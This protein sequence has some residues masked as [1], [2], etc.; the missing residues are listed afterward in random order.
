MFSPEW[1]ARPAKRVEP[2]L[3]HLPLLRAAGCA[4]YV[5][6]AAADV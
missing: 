4:Q 6:S 1:I 3:E 2:L 5:F